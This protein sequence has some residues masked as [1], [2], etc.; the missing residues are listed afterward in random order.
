MVREVIFEG[1]ATIGG[2]FEKEPFCIHD[3]IALAGWESSMM[4]VLQIKKNTPGRIS[5]GSKMH[6]IASNFLDFNLRF[7]ADHMLTLIIKTKSCPK[8][9]ISNR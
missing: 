6:P 5:I 2:P 9:A 8:C 1:F 7:L 4:F 3:F